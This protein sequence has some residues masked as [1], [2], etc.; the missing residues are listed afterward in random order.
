[1]SAAPRINW[2]ARILSWRQASTVP[3]LS[4]QVS[5]QLRLELYNM[6]PGQFIILS[7]KVSG[8][9]YAIVELADLQDLLA[10]AG[11]TVKML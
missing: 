11:M 5:E 6:L 3:V 7:S 9:E 2:W 1:M 4:T 10:R 8:R